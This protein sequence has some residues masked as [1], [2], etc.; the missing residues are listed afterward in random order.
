M[1]ARLYLSLSLL[2]ALLIAIVWMPLGRGKAL[3]SEAFAAS[4]A[5]RENRSSSLELGY[6][7]AGRTDIGGQYTSTTPTSASGT[8]DESVHLPLVVRN[9]QPPASGTPAPTSTPG[10]ATPISTPTPTSTP[11]SPTPTRTSTPTSTP[12]SEPLRIY[13]G[14]EYELKYYYNNIGHITNYSASIPFDTTGAAEYVRITVKI[15]D[16][17]SEQTKEFYLRGGENYT[18]SVYGPAFSPVNVLPKTYYLDVSSPSASDVK[19]VFLSGLDPYRPPAISNIAISGLPPTPTPTPTSTATPTRTPTP[20]ATFGPTPT[21]GACGI[22]NCDF[23]LGA[24]IWSEYS[25]NGWPLIRHADDLFLTSPHGG[26]WAAQLGGWIPEI[27]YLQQSVVVPSDRPYL[28]YWYYIYSEDDCGSAFAYVRINGNTVHRH[29]LCIAEST[30]DWVQNVVNLS[31]YAGQ[32]VQ[33]QVRVELAEGTSFSF[34]WLDD[35]AFR[36]TGN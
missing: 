20:T 5:S 18:L 35:F 30:A 23:E 7:D 16:T 34:F 11:S 14:S 13:W 10:G 36:S 26:S 28:G 1:K 24:V 32:T 27:A 19:T 2:C 21:P 29:D 33:L 22:V 3:L 6:G 17:Y 15:R 8:M 4:L 9:Y 25:Q 12:T 31:A